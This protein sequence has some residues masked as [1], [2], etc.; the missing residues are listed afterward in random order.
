MALCLC[1]VDIFL[2]IIVV[3]ELVSLRELWLRVLAVA[4]LYS[5]EEERDEAEEG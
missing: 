4:A 2:Y 3:V 1:T 5:L